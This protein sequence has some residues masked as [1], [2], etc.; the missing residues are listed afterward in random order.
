MQNEVIVAPPQAVA[1]S[2]TPTAETLIA[3]ALDKGLS[4]DTIEKLLAMRKE[5]KAE[6]AKEAYDAALAAFQADCPVIKKDKKVKFDTK[7]GGKVDYHYAPLD[8]I[9][10]QVKSL[11]AEH[12]FS[13][14]FK[15][16]ETHGSVKATCILKHK[17]GHFDT[18]D[19]TAEG[20]GTGLMSGAQIASGKAT[21]AKRQAF[22]NV[23]GITTGDEDTDAPLG[24]DEA[25]NKGAATQEQKDEIDALAQQ[26]GLTKAEVAKKC[27]EN[28]G[29]SITDITS[30]QAQGIIGGLKTR[31]AKA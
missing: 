11:I 5:L 25:K 26:A 1:V 27:R 4:V 7:N 14:S 3:Q 29:V 28:Y 21:F 31:I 10:K 6:A 12:G 23:L 9:V 24:K 8:S 30:V 22:C 15:I 18:S 2:P 17:A 13:Y 16:E 20:M 19:F